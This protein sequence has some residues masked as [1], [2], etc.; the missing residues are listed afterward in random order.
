VKKQPHEQRGWVKGISM[1]PNLIPGDILKAVDTPVAELKAGMIIVFPEKDRE[2]HI[3]HRVLSIRNVGNEFVIESGG[4]RSGPDDVKWY[5]AS[6]DRLRMVTSVLRRGHY[7]SIGSI[8]I[9][10]VLSPPLLVRV[11]CGFVR[12]LFW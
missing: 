9:P 2:N 12:R 4:D 11:H 8:S 10:A 5:Y 3:V 6:T 1:W 7:R